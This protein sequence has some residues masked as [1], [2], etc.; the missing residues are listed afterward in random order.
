MAKDQSSTSVDLGI[1]SPWEMDKFIQDHLL[2]DTTFITEIRADIDVISALL[3]E[4]CFQG[5]A[6]LV[7][8][9]RVVMGSSY[10][11]YTV[12][13]GRSEANLV[14]LFNNLKSFDDQ[15]ERRKEFI[16]EIRKH[17]SQL[18]QEKQL[19]EKFEILSSEHP[20]YR[21]LSFKL[22]YPQFQQEVKF[23]VQ[24][25]YDVLYEVKKKEE[26]DS[27]IYN[28]M[29]AKLIHECN[30]LNKAG[31][32]ANCF[33]ELQQNFLWKRPREL[34]NLICL[35]KHWYQLCKEKVRK[36]LPPQYA[37]ELLTVY[38]WET[39]TPDKCEGQTAQGFRTVLELI[40]QFLK[41]R[42]YW[43]YYYD[44]INE[45]VNAYLSTQVKKDRPM[46]LDPA[47]P[48]CNVAGFDLEGWH[49]LA[50]EAKAWL[51]YSCF[52]LIDDT[53]VGSWNVPP[54]KQGCFFQ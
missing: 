25:A 1:I 24:P 7:R 5:A 52:R 47:D 26:V 45:E 33:L 6:H 20:N 23:D 16:K 30:I 41:L 39:E 11:E 53:P 49:L 22:S 4:R 13:K 3:K 44:A 34:K 9:S 8:V 29:Y 35:V 31:K 28:K 51:K 19:G 2:G 48:T 38:A 21:Y 14:V 54:E 12:L 36:P 37:L 32:Y 40:I 50:E 43:T 10:N 42:I 15:F 27:E 18:Q 46:I 17:L